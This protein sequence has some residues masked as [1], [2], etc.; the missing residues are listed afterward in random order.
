MEIRERALLERIAIK[1][2][3]HV[4]LLASVMV[5]RHPGRVVRSGRQPMH[6]TP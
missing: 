5:R 1:D 4:G 2:G 3:R 6:L